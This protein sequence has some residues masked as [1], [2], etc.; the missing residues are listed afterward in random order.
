MFVESISIMH[1]KL[2]ASVMSNLFCQQL[3]VTSSGVEMRQL[4]QTL[5]FPT[6]LEMTVCVNITM[7]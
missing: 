3:P 7:T 4:T 6:P 1:I 2:F 5:Y